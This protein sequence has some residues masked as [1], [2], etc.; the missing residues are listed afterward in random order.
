MVCTR[1]GFFFFFFFFLEG[2]L[3]LV[4]EK[5]REKGKRKKRE[6][7]DF[8]YRRTLV[9]ACLTHPTKKKNQI[10]FFPSSR[11]L[12]YILYLRIH[13]HISFFFL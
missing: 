12:L 11:Y 13:I 8:D 1:C 2:V 5:E 4:E 9:V 10:P 3:G 7:E 6:E